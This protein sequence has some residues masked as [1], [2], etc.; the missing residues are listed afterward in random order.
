[1]SIEQIQTSIIHIAPCSQEI[2]DNEN[3]IFLRFFVWKM[4]NEAV[5]LPCN[6]NC[7]SFHGNHGHY[8]N[9]HCYQFKI[10]HLVMKSVI[11]EIFV[12]KRKFYDFSMIWNAFK[13]FYFCFHGK[14]SHN[15]RLTVYLV[16]SLVISY[17]KKI[18][19]VNTF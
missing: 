19:S 3:P 17:V 12:T 7:F 4:R 14:H 2:I 1:V 13:M 5:Q 6:N 9:F 18:I 16:V 8:L 10:W 11:M 15:L